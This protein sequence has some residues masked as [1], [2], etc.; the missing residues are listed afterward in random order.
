MEEIAPTV[1]ISI[2]IN[3]DALFRH[4]LSDSLI[5]ISLS[6]RDSAAV[7]AI[8]ESDLVLT[9]VA[10]SRSVLSQILY[11]MKLRYDR[12]AMFMPPHPLQGWFEQL[13]FH[14]QFPGRAAVDAL[15]SAERLGAACLRAMT[16]LVK[17]FELTDAIDISVFSVIFFR[18]VFDGAYDGPSTDPPSAI[19]GLRLRV[20]D[21]AAPLAFLPQ[22]EPEDALADVVARDPDLAQA[23]REIGAAAFCNSPLDVLYAVHLS[24]AQVRKSVRKRDVESVQSFDIVFGLFLLVLLASDLPDPEAVIRLVRDHAP[25]EGLAGPL[26]YARSTVVAAGVQCALIVDRERDAGG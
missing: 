9:N 3:F 11:T 24:L 26:E 10:D 8:S 17:L 5:G 18:A 19:R 21:S 7:A 2:E 23:A 16:D 12:K 20:A 22:C 13:L 6:A 1:T 15:A 25:A 4:W 14:P